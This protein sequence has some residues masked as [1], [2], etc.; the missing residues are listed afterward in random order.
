MP[1][2][3]R[4]APPHS[5]PAVSGATPMTL[6]SVL[7]VVELTHVKVGSAVLRAVVIPPLKSPSSVKT[8]RAVT[9]PGVELLGDPEPT[10]TEES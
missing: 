5:V 10:E 1:E 6:S 2:S 9:A 4:A 7:A 3:E 8:T